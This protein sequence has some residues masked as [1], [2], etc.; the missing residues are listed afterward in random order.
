MIY[1]Y[2][3]YC[4][5]DSTQDGSIRK[6]GEPKVVDY[7]AEVQAALAEASAGSGAKYAAADA[8]AGIVADVMELKIADSASAALAAAAAAPAHVFTLDEDF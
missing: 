3:C 8:S 2:I 4:Y 5:L 1:P 6:M 7:V